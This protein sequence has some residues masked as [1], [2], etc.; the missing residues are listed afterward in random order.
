MENHEKIPS[1]ISYSKAIGPEWGESVDPKSIAMV[2]TKLQLEV[3][4][5]SEELDFILQALEGMH[6]LDSYH[7]KNVGASPAYTW[8]GPEVIIKDYLTRMFESLLKVERSFKPQLRRETPVDIVVTI[9]A[10][11]H[12]IP[13]CCIPLCCIPLCYKGTEFPI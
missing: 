3:S 6:N 4:D 1:V 13:L 9:P 2:H 7:V 5:T 11:C 12:G 10:V 8:K